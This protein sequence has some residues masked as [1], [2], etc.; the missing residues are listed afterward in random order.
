MIG[1]I[2]LIIRRIT[3]QHIQ[4]STISTLYHSISHWM[5]IRTCDTTM[6]TKI[7]T[8]LSKLTAADKLRSLIRYQFIKYKNGGMMISFEIQS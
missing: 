7:S 8:K 5:I 6:N 4:Q 2:S 3:T 1:P